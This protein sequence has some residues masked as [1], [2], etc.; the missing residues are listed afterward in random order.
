MRTCISACAA[1]AA[2]LMLS[3]SAADALGLLPDGRSVTPTG[4]TIP[5]EGF[6]S[7]AVLSPDGRWIAVLSQDGNA[8]DVLATGEDARLVDRLSA[9]F[10][11]GLTWTA[12]GL[13]VT[14]GFSGYIS[15]Y[16][17]DAPDSADGPAFVKRADLHIGGLVNGI[18]EDPATHRIVVA[19]TAMREVDVVS[20]A[21]NAV[22][23]QLSAS[24][25]P[26]SVAM[27][28]GKIIATLY[29]SDHVDVWTS[30]S[31]APVRIPTGA[32]PTELLVNRQHAFVANAGGAD[33]VE[34]D[35]A[36]LAVVRRFDLSLQPLP[37]IGQTPSGMALSADGA[38][39]FVA[40][41]G[42]DDVAV[43]DQ[44]S[45]TV[46]GR[47][48]TGWYPMTVLARVGVT[49]D[50]E[51]QP[52][53][54]LWIV[55]ANGLGTQPDPGSEWNGWYTGIVQHLIFEPARLPVW[56]AQVAADNHFA[57]TEPPAA[58][59]PPIK[60]VVFIVRENKHFDE[61]FGD[62]PNADADPALLLYGRYFTPNAHALAE[63]NT[64][65]DEFMGDGQAS[66]YGHAWTTQGMVSDYQMRNAHTPDDPASK[67]DL[68]VPYSIWPYAEAGEDTVSLTAMDFDW[69]NNRS[70]LPGGP[71]VDVSGVFGP[72]GELIDGFE[73]KGVSY[74]VYGEQMTVVPGGNIAPG[75]AANADRDYPGAHIDFSIADTH[76]ADLF[77]AD[78]RAHGLAAYS[79]VTLPTDHTAGT[80]GGFYTPASY[81]A[82]NDLALGQIIE[83]LSHM[84][85]WRDTIVFVTTD[86]P[87]GTGDHVDSH[88]QP[89]FVIGPYVRH[90]YVDHT[91]YDIPS[92]L[93]T[94]EVLFGIEPLNMYDAQA[95]PMLDAFASQPDVAT[96]TAIASNIPMT[97]N[98][99]KT[100]SMA[101]VL[102]GPDSFA[103]PDQEWRAIKGSASLAE[104]IAYLRRLGDV[105]VANAESE[106]ETGGK[107]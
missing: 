20:D 24:G 97:K 90:G 106:R 17:Y 96:Y 26:F 78:V 7:S 103:I 75:L 83:G 12:D 57:V 37:P 53:Q 61:E 74:R 80:K 66:I 95:T 89:A 14:R 105:R 100:A 19:R 30:G 1:L 15:R 47:I 39:L 13:Y 8:V 81:V 48:P 5:V 92:I 28:D 41:S 99:G 51:T 2:A 82:N 87:Q 67:S 3:A 62:E 69:Y 49:I 50:K 38:D 10:A 29:D 101:F 11:S 52:K 16:R 71:R 55:S 72:N 88:R 4:F 86:D 56:T 60:H 45:G 33:V 73:R 32:H 107:R 93:R 65:F 70:E 44:A 21:S 23:A 18:A 9:P 22:L 25:Q 79:Y 58:Q 77:L 59:L 63:Q 27:Y 98:P 43:V 68:R 85:E 42:F 35:L 102:D 76:R 91:R 34:I 36:A 84:P 6:A 40:E 104:H 94:V 46:T 31:V 54:Q 64:L